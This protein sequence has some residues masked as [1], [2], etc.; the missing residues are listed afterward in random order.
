MENIVSEKCYFSAF[1]PSARQLLT[2][3]PPLQ[4]TRIPSPALVEK[5]FNLSDYT[6]SEKMLI[7][8]ILQVHNHDAMRL[9]PRPGLG[10]TSEMLLFPPGPERRLCEN[11]SKFHGLLK[12]SKWH[13]SGLSW[14]LSKN[15]PM[16]GLELTFD[17]SPTFCGLGKAVPHTFPSV[18]PVSAPL[19][20][21][22]RPPLKVNL[23]PKKLDHCVTGAISE[24]LLSVSWNRVPP[25]RVNLAAPIN[26]TPP[27]AWDLD[28]FGSG[29]SPNP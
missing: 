12:N 25:A 18:G 7:S 14:D 29:I 11:M 3:L 4:G 10:K 23:R 27:P 6:F 1:V 15:L 19:K 16:G 2:V 8:R 22:S 13:H 21:C 20:V 9:C 26:L 28:F 5:E 24:E 17:C